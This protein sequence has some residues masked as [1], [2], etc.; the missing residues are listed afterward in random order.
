[1]DNKVRSDSFWK[2]FA[3]I[4]LVALVSVVGIMFWQKAN[5]RPVFYERTLVQPQA[6]MANLPPVYEVDHSSIYWVADLAEQA[7]P[8]VVNVET[9]YEAE[10][11][12]EEQERTNE[13]MREM[14]EQLPEFFNFDWDSEEFNFEQPMPRG[15][16][17]SG[18]I[19]REDGYIVTNAHVVTGANKFL[20]H[21]DEGDVY[22]AELIGTDAFKDIAVL[23]IDTDDNLP[24]AVLGD[25]DETRIGEP[26]VAIGSPLG[27]EA[28][29]TAGIV[30]TIDRSMD[31]LGRPTDVRR[32]KGFIQTDAAINPGN[33]G[34]PLLNSR[35]EVIG[36]N[37]AI[38]RW[39][40]GSG[41][42]GQGAVP[43]EGI[44]FAIPINEVKETIEHIVK[45][46]KVVYPGIQ[47][48]IMSVEDLLMME[49]NLE[50]D[51]ETGVFVRSVTIGGPA[52]R[53]GIKA[54]DVILSIEG[55]EVSTAAE[56]ISEI[57]N[58]DV[59]ERVTLRVARQ[60][61]ETH[62]DVTVVL[63]ELDL[64]G[65]QVE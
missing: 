5:D 31:D 27:F 38:V 9:V 43:I 12:E 62:E 55:I 1:M 19:V 11:A 8:F 4:L 57:Q 18:F 60:G 2:V 20:V 32:P 53:G 41:M 64:S 47:A 46:G 24:V 17:G 21:V 26:V 40:P 7:L 28:T 58:F 61:G 39:Q 25:S 14:H 13:M 65:I 22:E 42:F 50:L 37:Q 15:G 33:S 34:G 10:N 36:V 56:L 6:N 44:G 45:N 52:D 48:Q 54:G 35:G 30:S 63:G 49:P 59:G 29:V 16:E 3:V 51:V 23:K